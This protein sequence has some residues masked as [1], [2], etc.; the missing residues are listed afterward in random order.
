MRIRFALHPVPHTGPSRTGSSFLLALLLITSGLFVSCTEDEPGDNNQQQ[1]TA[2]QSPPATVDT[3]GLP[4]F[5]GQSAYDYVA[6]Q[7]ALGPRNP[8]SAGAKKAI[9]FYMEEFGKYADNVEAQEFTHMGYEGEKLN[10]TNIFASFNPNSGTRIL[11]CAHWDSRP[12]ADWDP[13]STKHD[14]A[15]PAANDGGSGAGVLLE[16]ARMFKENPPPVG[17]DIVLFDGEDYGDTRIDNV[18][19]YFLGARYFSRNIPTG[20]R[21]AFGI[22]LDLVG[23]RDAEFAKEGISMQYASG[24]VNALWH[25]AQQMGL[26]RFKQ[27]MGSP[28]QDDHM[29]LNEI[30]HIPTLDIIDADLVGHKSSDPRRKYWHTHKDDMENISAATLEEVG[31]LLVYT[32]YRWLPEQV[33]LAS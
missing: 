23:D 11:L 19:Q 33:K 2:A 10:L 3:T 17:V 13:D 9:A 8:G 16:L 31:K 24:Y 15:I 18:E 20:Y 6:K 1:N 7:V 30:A 27:R 4:S 5:S 14:I 29:I 25:A 22:L 28:I 21:P 32:V 26:T 12:R